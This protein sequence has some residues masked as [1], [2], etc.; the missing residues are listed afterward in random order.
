MSN[1]QIDSSPNSFGAWTGSGAVTARIDK[2]LDTFRYLSL[3]DNAANTRN[4]V[5]KSKYT[6]ASGSTIITLEDCY[7]E[8]FAD[9][10]YNFHAR[11]DDSNVE[12]GLTVNRS[13]VT[14]APK[15]DCDTAQCCG[16]IPKNDCDAAQCC[17]CSFKF[18]DCR[19][20][21]LPLAIIALGALAVAGTKYYQ[22]QTK[23]CCEK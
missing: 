4:I 10:T 13:A 16:D 15:D 19:K 2:E 6:V 1:T 9:G 14:S 7:L 11:F 17:C 18:D 23:R 3:F 5:D 22:K 21:V 20:L 12:L 8:T